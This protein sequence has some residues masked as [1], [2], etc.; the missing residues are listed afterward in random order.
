MSAR[1][2]R[3]LRERC[4]ALLDGAKLRWRSCVCDCLEAWRRGCGS[5]EESGLAEAFVGTDRRARLGRD[6]PGPC[7][8]GRRRSTRASSIVRSSRNS[9]AETVRASHSLQSLLPM[10]DTVGNRSPLFGLACGR[11]D[12]AGGDVCDPSGRVMAEERFSTTTLTFMRVRYSL[13]T[14][15]LEQIP[16]LLYL[17]GGTPPEKR[18]GAC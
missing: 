15:V 6:R 5:I 10:A 9:Q 3:L 11:D 18:L 13:T 16:I 1:S 7:S 17:G 12:H 4:H 8:R 2:G 14:R